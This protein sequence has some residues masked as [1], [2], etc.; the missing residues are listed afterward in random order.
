MK[1]TIQLQESIFHKNESGKQFSVLVI[2]AN[3][4][5][6][7]S[8]VLGVRIN[9]A[10]AVKCHPISPAKLQPIRPEADNMT[11]VSIF[12]IIGRQSIT[13]QCPG[14]MILLLNPDQQTS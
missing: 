13:S 10:S 11:Q 14:L 6:I 7:V 2:V 9:T 4:Y 5:S 1:A 8:N 12:N 3:P